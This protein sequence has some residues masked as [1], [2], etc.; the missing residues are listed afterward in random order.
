MTDATSEPEK[1]ILQFPGGTA[2]FPVVRGTAGHDSIDI[3]TFTKQTGFTTLDQ[4]FVNT[5]STR[6]AITYI[7]GDKGV[8]RYRG[9]SI[10]DVA[11]RS[12][13]VRCPF[14]PSKVKRRQCGNNQRFGR[15]WICLSLAEGEDELIFVQAPSIR[16]E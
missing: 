2:E 3:S 6:S 11:Q 1:A 10:E 16:E 5:A 12:I 7:D 9:Y 4:G 14:A 13:R 8:L 15:E